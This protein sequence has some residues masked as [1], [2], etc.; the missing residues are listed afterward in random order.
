MLYP[1]ITYIAI[2]P[3]NFIA[4]ILYGTDLRSH[5]ETTP[6]QTE[7]Y[8][9]LTVRHDVISGKRE[10]SLQPG[11]RDFRLWRETGISVLHRHSGG[12]TGRQRG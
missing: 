3:V 6:R 7:K 10:L 2:R 9:S 1:V 12:L 4:T 5:Q 8:Y 11:F